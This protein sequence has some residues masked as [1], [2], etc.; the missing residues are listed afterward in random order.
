MKR[1]LIIRRTVRKT[2]DAAKLILG[3]RIMRSI[4]IGWVTMSLSDAYRQRYASDASDK[5][6][7]TIGGTT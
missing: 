4:G 3:V 6:L 1:I 2:A 7:L 5:I